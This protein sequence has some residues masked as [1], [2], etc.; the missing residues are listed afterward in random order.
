M[1]PSIYAVKS[2]EEKPNPTKYAMHTH[3]NYEIF[4]FLS[5]NAKYFV[6]GNIYTLRA[7]DILIM[8]KAEAHSLLINSDIPYERIVINFNSE[9]IAEDV[10]EEVIGFLDTRPLGI[11]NRYPAALFK[12]TNWAHYLNK[13]CTLENPYEQKAYLTVLLLELRNT[14]SQIC[15]KQVAGGDIMNILEYINGHLEDDL[16]LEKITNRFYISRSHINRKFKKIIG[17]TVKQYIL[18]KRLLLAKE[19]L[20]GGEHPTKVY[21]KCGFNDYCTFFRSYKTRFGIS[22]KSTLSKR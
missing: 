11:N 14:Y 9:A 16:S 8:K 18:T 21:L 19:L 22:P 15:G 6:E 5:G 13:I 1:T 2:H 12:D 7:G 4:C 10:R 20:Q 3:D 17:T